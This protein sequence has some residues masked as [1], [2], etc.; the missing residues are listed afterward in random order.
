MQDAID[1]LLDKLVGIWQRR[2]WIVAV[3]WVVSMAGWL[4][5]HQMADRYE[6]QARIFVDTDTVLK[7]LLRGLALQEDGADDQVQLMFK[8][9][10]NRNNLEKIA[11]LSDL[12]LTV[13]NEREFDGLIAELED[14]IKTIKLDKKQN[15]Y[16][17]TYQ[18]DSPQAAKRVLDATISVFQENF[19]GEPRTESRSAQEFLDREIAEYSRRL[20][21]EDRKLADFKRENAGLLPGEAGSYYER[22]QAERRQLEAASLDLSEREGQLQAATAKLA[23]SQGRASVPSAIIATRFDERI[24]SLQARLDDLSLRFTEQHPDIIELQQLI[25]ELERQRTQELENLRKR[26]S[27]SAP[28]VADSAYY[29]E[30]QLLVAQMEAEVASLRIRVA[31]FQQ[32]V[33]ELEAVIS[34]VPEV[35]ANL[36]ALRRG[37]EITQKKYEELLNRREQASTAQRVD[38]QQDG[39]KF[40]IIDQPRVLPDPVGPPRLMLLSAVLMVGLGGGLGVP[41]LL[42]EMN[43]RIFRGRTLV[44]LTNIPLLGEVTDSQPVAHS[45]SARLGLLLFVALLGALL[46]LYLVQVGL[47]LYGGDMVLDKVRGLARGGL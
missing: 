7:P 12:D 40:R 13:T 35:E 26:S 17:L 23:G 5:V 3:A 19:L 28:V 42:G 29:N 11:R 27:S 47:L 38:E 4:A 10:L 21:E 33:T 20:L 14:A 15:L 34:K 24:A 22:L 44:H 9:I 31:T 32:R 39:L 1:Q 45:W 25:A 41:F 43:P 30:L 36:L 6:A 2:W 18:S 16:L 8:Y 46:T 37:Y